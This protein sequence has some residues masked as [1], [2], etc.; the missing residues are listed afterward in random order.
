M[1]FTIKDL[2]EKLKELPEDLEVH[3]MKECS[4]YLDEYPEQQSQNWAE[5]IKPVNSGPI[6]TWNNRLKQH[7]KKDCV[8]VAV[9]LEVLVQ[10]R[11]E[12]KYTY[13]GP[14]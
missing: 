7:E 13:L 12:Y 2:I 1:P 8:R 4:D 6:T 5:Y 10:P 11:T 14:W 3:L 9:G